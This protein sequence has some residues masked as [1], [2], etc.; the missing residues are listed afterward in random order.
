MTLDTLVTSDLDLMN[1][2][3]LDVHRWSDHPEVKQLIDQL[4]G[5]L[6]FL[7]KTLNFFTSPLLTLFKVTLFPLY[8]AI[9]LN[10]KY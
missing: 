10:L 5:V 9:S 3:P 6:P 7:T 4:W 8:V 1:A 2:R